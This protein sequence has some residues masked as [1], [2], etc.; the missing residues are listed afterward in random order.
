MTNTPNLDSP[1][2]EA[3]ITDTINGKYSIRMFYREVYLEFKEKLKKIDDLNG[4][5]VELGAGGGFVKEIVPQVI[6]TDI[7]AYKNIDKV[8]DA[9]RMS[10]EDNSI[11]AILMINVFHHISNADAFFKEL[12]RCLVPGGLVYI[13]DQNRGLISTPILKKLHHEPYDDKV[14]EWSFHPRGP[15][16]GANGALPWIVFRRDQKIFEARYPLLEINSFEPKAP[17]M[18]WLAGGLKSWTLVPEAL[19]LCV[20]LLDSFLLKVSKRFGSFVAIEIIKRPERW[21]DEN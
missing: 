5:V 14:L 20:K 12:N 19:Y 21:Q 15:L 8:V 10:F 18:Y 7:I 3:E 17:L 9:C 13:F 4:L 1:L 11:K 6:T 16:S 2:R